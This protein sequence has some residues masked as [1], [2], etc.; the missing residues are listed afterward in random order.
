MIDILQGYDVATIILY[1]VVIATII[2][3]VNVCFWEGYIFQ[4]VGDYME[5]NY[6]ELW[7][8][9]AGCIVCMSVWWGAAMCMNFGWP[10]LSIIVAMG[11]NVIIVK[12]TPKD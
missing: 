10:Y 1:G 12:W 9:I 6:P 5:V 8:P 4:R 11:I 7:K 2:N 3:S